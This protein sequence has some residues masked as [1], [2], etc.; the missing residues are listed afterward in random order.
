MRVDAYECDWCHRREIEPGDGWRE[1]SHRAL[2]ESVT[3][4][5]H[6]CRSCWADLAGLRGRAPQP[7]ASTGTAS[8]ESLSAVHGR[9]MR[10]VRRVYAEHE[11]T[12]GEEAEGADG[13][14]PGWEV[15]E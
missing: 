14:P 13:P 8:E 5:E 1:L 6:A 4:T 9:L 11:V 7:A 2:D 15:G 10:T 3:V 12:P